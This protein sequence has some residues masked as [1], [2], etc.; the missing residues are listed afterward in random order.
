MALIQGIEKPQVQRVYANVSTPEES[1]NFILNSPR[2]PGN[3][4]GGPGGGPG[5]LGTVAEPEKAAVHIVDGKY[6]RGTSEPSIIFG[7]YADD[8][9]AEDLR[10]VTYSSNVGGVYVEGSSHYQLNNSAISIAGNGKT[11]GGI[12]SGAAVGNNGELTIRDSVIMTNGEER[13][14]TGADTGGVLRVYNSTLISQGAPFGEDAPAERVGKSTP[15]APLEIK[16]NCRT[17]CTSSRGMSYFYDCTLVGDGWAVLST[18]RSEGY[19]YLEANDSTVKALKSGYGTYADKFCHC[20]F[21]R[22]DFDVAVMAVILDGESSISFHDSKIKCGK[23]FAFIH[24]SGGPASQTGDMVVKNCKVSCG[25]DVFTMRSHN[26]Q[27]NIE[28][29]QLETLGGRFIH[30]MYNLDDQAPFVNGEKVFGYHVDI[31]DCAISGDVVH[32]DYERDTYLNLKSTTLTGSIQNAHLTMDEGSKWVATGDSRVVFDHCTVTPAQIDGATGVTIRA[33]AENE[34]VFTMA[35]GGKLIVEKYTGEPLL[36]TP[37]TPATVAA[38]GGSG[39]HGGLGGPGGSGGAPFVAGES[40]DG[41]KFS[42]EFNA[43]G[44]ECGIV[45]TMMPAEGPMPARKEIVWDLEHSLIALEKVTALSQKYEVLEFQ[46][47][48]DHWLM[49]AMV[50]KKAPTCTMTNNIP[51]FPK[52]YPMIPLK[53]GVTPADSNMTFEIHEKGD[54]LQVLCTL[55]RKGSPEDN[56]A[57]I[58]PEIP[59]GK[60][61]YLKLVGEPSPI[62]IPVGLG[63]AYADRCTALF[64]GE[65]YGDN[66]RCSVTYTDAFKVGD[67]VKNP[68]D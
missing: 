40:P 15:P 4:R 31:K 36:K 22:C 56:L 10:V 52:P 42:I 50:E 39:G 25:D 37:E 12:R 8:N 24:A 57:I 59:A 18:D 62:F 2:R 63:G 45:P 49:M 44:E 54:D 20:V 32:E 67:T 35:S 28:K 60:R 23:Y 7:G 47:H 5:G 14:A 48:P 51:I 41:K 55:L 53:T 46:G 1:K 6:D 64:I 27:L 43:F 16:G 13:S 34:G 9:Q 21:N 26:I 17:H 19:V 33:Y 58:A 65:R 66:Y 38:P 61:V 68:F 11:F 3:K 30:T 29:S